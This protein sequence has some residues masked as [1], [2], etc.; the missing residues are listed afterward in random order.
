MKFMNFCVITLRMSIAWYCKK[1]AVTNKK[2]KETLFAFHEHQ[3]Q[4]EDKVHQL[5]DNMNRK[6]EDMVHAMSDQLEEM[7]STLNK[8]LDKQDTKESVEA[9]DEKVNKIMV[10]MEKQKVDNREIHDCVQDAVR[11]K[12]QEDKEESEEIKK[13]STSII[14]HGLKEST[15]VDGDLRKKQDEELLISVLHEIQ[16]DDVSV[17]GN[18][19]LGRYDSTQSRP[20]PVKVVVSSE[21]QKDKVLKQA[22]NVKGTKV[23]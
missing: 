20:R 5:E 1:C 21:R 4:V 9:V 12:L 14:V 22:K 3:L 19:R 16:C 13:R 18:V 10:T 8:K 7:R 15:E 23:Q 11:M 6:L 17:E 2:L